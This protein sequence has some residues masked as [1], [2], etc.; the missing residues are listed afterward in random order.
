MD[1]ADIADC[2]KQFFEDLFRNPLTNKWTTYCSG[3]ELME[4]DT[5]IISEWM[6]FFA[7]VVLLFIIMFSSRK[8]FNH[9]SRHLTF[10]AFLVWFF[11]VYIY[12]IGFYT[13]E[14]NALSV[15]P[16]AIISSFRMFVVSND[17]A[18]I[19][20]GLQKNSMYM[21][22]F[23]LVHFAAA[24]ITFIFIFKM[25]GYKVRCYWNTLIHRLFKSRGKV[26][27][28]FW[29]VNDASLLLAEDIRNGEKESKVRNP[30]TIIFVDIDE[31]KTDNT[32]KKLTLAHITDA[33]TVTDTEIIRMSDVNALVGHCYDGPALLDDEQK[34]KDVFGSLNL[35]RI[36]RIVRNSSKCFFYFMS[37]DQ[38]RNVTGALNLQKDEY[39]LS[40][41]EMPEIYVHARRDASNE[42]FDHYS[43][44]DEDARR[45]R[46]NIID[47]AYL[48]IID[49]KQSDKALP[50]NCV[51]H[52]R[53]TG[54][55]DSPFT[56]MIVGFGE[57]GQ[58]A[59]RFLYEFS[60]F[61]GSDMQKSPFKCYA[62]DERMS[63]L[64]G[65]F[66]VKVPA[67][68]DDELEFIQTSVES[69]DFWKKVRSVISELNYIVIALNDDAVGL[70][71][72][73]ELFKY[74]LK[75][76]YDSPAPLKIMLRCYESANENKMKEVINNL[77]DS[78]GDSAVGMHLF[79]EKKIIFRSA[80]TLQDSILSKAKEF[81]Y[82]YS[83]PDLSYD[84]LWGGL[85]KETWN[86]LVA[87]QWEKDFIVDAQK[88]LTAIEKA[89]DKAKAVGRNMSRYHAIYDI[90]R[91]IGQNVS[92]S[93]HKKTKLILLGLDGSDPETL[94]HYYDIVRT[95]DNR[96]CK[97]E[98]HCS[99]DES[100]LLINL[101]MV[102]HERWIAAHKL[103][104]FTPGPE[105]DMVKKRHPDMVHWSEL[106]ETTESYDCNVVDTTIRIAYQRL[107]ANNEA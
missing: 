25:V 90:N 105:K 32:K 55:V 79:G 89:V 88:N 73:V 43:Q 87:Q 40:M 47:S 95:R 72:A 66:K 44:Y 24:F 67:I 101:A 8:I 37:D 63:K 70:S 92:N 33:I 94:K 106:T 46:V 81:H 71:L 12:V 99:G 38:D 22:W 42:V 53:A 61:V 103:L 56:S 20:S 34:M 98:Y 27:H 3:P 19:P 54:L 31:E 50:V 82:I 9:L 77:N 52:D 4:A 107:V 96:N 57:T 104:G 10:A 91:M 62:I 84:Q 6:I 65:L 21:T 1:I 97:T 58:E 49:L 93:L 85:D 80:N 45:M 69:E 51:H 35:K 76:R 83:N 5:F 78:V 11:G 86:A 59:F 7:L 64:S 68:T 2:H 48:S 39:L 60:A 26:V 17:L 16:R 23:S 74:A 15:V 14:V 13:K 100:K 30:C 29:G 28:L 75:H 41:P 102:E 36:G 18:R